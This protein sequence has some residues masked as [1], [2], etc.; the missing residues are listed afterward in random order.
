APRRAPRGPVVPDVGNGS[1][2]AVTTLAG[3]PYDDGVRS[4]GSGV[5]G[6]VAVVAL[7]VALLA[8][9]SVDVVRAGYGV[10]G[11]EATYV[12]MA[13]SMAYDGDLTYER[14]DLERFYG[15]YQTG[16]EGVFLK[17]GKRIRGF[18]LD[19]TPPFLHL[20]KLPDDRG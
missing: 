12:A 14:R 19:S 18:N 5:V 17:R 9:V 1:R 2:S 8:A 13:L 15:L 20:S 3:A 4:P 7:A 11:D 16:P 6:P 10:K